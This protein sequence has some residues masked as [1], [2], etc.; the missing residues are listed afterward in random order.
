MMDKVKK[1]SDFMKDRKGNCAQAVFTAFSEDLG[2][3]EKTAF[4]TAQGFGGGMHIS[5]ICGAVTGAYMALGLANPVSPENPRQSMDK[6]NAL[7]AEFTRRFKELHGS[8]NCSELVEYDLS[9]PEEAAKARESGVFAD[10]CPVFVS[11]AVKIVQELL[12]SA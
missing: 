5:S 12:K 10:K 2:L 3:D 11:D 6:T 9:I 7:M 1:A 4:N 8:L